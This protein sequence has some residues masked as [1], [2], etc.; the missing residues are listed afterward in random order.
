MLVNMC[1]NWA[2]IDNMLFDIGT[3]TDL[4]ILTT[5]FWDDNGEWQDDDVWIDI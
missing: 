1:C 4:W 2:F 3:P 5:G